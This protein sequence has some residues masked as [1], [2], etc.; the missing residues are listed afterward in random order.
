MQQ[1]LFDEPMVNLI[2]V[3]EAAISAKVSTATIRNWVKIGYLKIEK[4]G[5]IR[6]DVLTSFLDG[7]SGSKKLTGR[8]NKSKK[9]FHDHEALS[10]KINLLLKNLNSD[11]SALSDTYES[12][13]SESF[14][15]KEGIFYT[16]KHVVENL[17][18][19][20]QANVSSL[21]FLDPCCG[22]G[23]FILRAIDLGF[24]PEN[25][26]GYDTDPIAV[27]LTKKRILSKTGYVTEN[28]S[29][30][31]F[32]SECFTD[33]CKS[34]DVIYTNPPWGKKLDKVEKIKLGKAFGADKSIDSCSLFFFACLKQLK[35]GGELGLLLPDSFF[36][37][38]T[39]ESARV[40]SLNLQVKKLID[41]DRPFKKLQTKAFG[42]VL[43][44]TPVIKNENIVL[45]KTQENTFERRQSSFCRNPKS[46]I[47]FQTEPASEAVIEHLFK[48]PH[49]TLL[50]KAKWGLG[51]VT[52]NNEKFVK[53]THSE[54]HIP[55][56]R[57]ADISKDGLAKPSCYIPSDLSLYQQV[58]PI[59]IYQ[60]PIK[61]IYKFISS[62][63]CFFCD[64][65]QRFLLNSANILI[66]SKN[67][68]ISP[69]QLSCLLNS[70]I[71]NWMFFS[72]FRTHKILRADLENIP[73]HVEYFS[74][75]L[76]F[77]EDSY[78]EYLCLERSNCGAYRIKKEDR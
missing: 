18:D 31:D 26:Y 9:D 78:L 14:R 40:R 67:L 74:E 12:S 39:F 21:K 43:K 5:F 55:V 77:S 50:G 36:N 13:L 53:S 29:H 11:F 6:N 71:I 51:I 37:V 24:L 41:Y 32:F 22:S 8:A 70:E 73:I 20:N 64:T 49:I 1:P 54:G 33:K 3:D 38:A 66:P 72:I 65:E 59:E 56:F 52:G 46:I 75:N 68:K 63:L 4:K 25:V 7:R 35:Q 62:T 19:F 27:E 48:F 76:E 69:H 28:V 60:A 44:N 61:L 42:F 58:A 30:A 45:C 57:G 23:N 47:N 17:F 15:N 2:S 34:F 16:P 10:E